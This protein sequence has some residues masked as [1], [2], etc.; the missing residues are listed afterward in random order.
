MRKASSSSS[1]KVENDE[2]EED[3]EGDEEEEEE[4]DG[5]DEEEGGGDEF[6]EEKD[7]TFDPDKKLEIQ[8]KKCCKKIELFLDGVQHIVF[9]N[10]LIKIWGG[11]NNK[12]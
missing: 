2:E 10:N 9:F 11:G 5:E 12:N 6:N 1:F 3:G 4:E 8:E 7:P